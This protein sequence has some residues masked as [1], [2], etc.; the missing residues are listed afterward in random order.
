MS[1]L[2]EPSN[3]NLTRNILL[4]ML[5]GFIA[6]MGLNIVPL[7]SQVVSFVVSGPLQVGSSI[8]LASLKLLVVPLVF[9]SI[10]CGTAALDDV[11]KLGRL[12]VRTLALYLGTTAVAVSL[13]LSVATIASPG[14]GFDLTSETEFVAPDAPSLAE[15]I[16]ALVPTN[17]LAAMVDGNMLQIITFALLLGVAITM[18]GDAGSRILSVFRDLDTVIMRLVDIVMSI[19]PFGVFCLVA[20]VFG[21]QGITAVVPLLRYFLCVATVLGLHVV[22]TYASLV[23]LVARRSPIAFLRAMRPVALVAF[24]TSSSNATI[25]VTRD[26]AEKVLGVPSSIASFT[27]PLGATI[28]M[29][30]TAIMQG[31]ATAFIAQAYGIELS[32]SAYVSV[33]LTATLASVGTAG[34]P[35]VGL[36]TLAMVLRQVGLPVEGIG[37]IIGVDRLL[38]MLR[39]AVNVLGDG[40]VTCAVAQLETK[41]TTAG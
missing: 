12:G 37:L 22:I 31:V 30:G 19:A 28:N 1:D 4:G 5:F 6:G 17:P 20:K 38:D 23:Q 27:V 24:S 39:T 40:A 25:P 33:V 34:V 2:I 11:A 7:S 32:I 35:G 16:I 9:V 14:S 15:T 3:P 26:A 13:A 8:F 29:D 18:A 10:V 21:D 41:Q 36:I